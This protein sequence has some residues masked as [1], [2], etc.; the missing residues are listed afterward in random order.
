MRR[1]LLFG[2]LVV[3]LAFGV[4]RVDAMT[5]GNH[6]ALVA[7]HHQVH[8]VSRGVDAVGARSPDVE[9]ISGAI[10]P[11]QGAAASAASPGNLTLAVFVLAIAGAIFG[12]AAAGV[13]AVWVMDDAT[14]ASHG[15]PRW[16]NS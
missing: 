14:S 2:P 4:V 1:S 5:V 11:A 13:K 16:F 8:V 10:R 3:V 6:T 9:G 12:L 7:S 15:W